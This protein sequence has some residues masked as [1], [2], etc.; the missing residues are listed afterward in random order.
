MR[1]RKSEGEQVVEATI[2]RYARGRCLRAPELVPLKLLFAEETE[3]AISG[4]EEQGGRGQGT[5]RKL[6]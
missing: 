2:L 4:D 5:K 3:E 6:E 1:A